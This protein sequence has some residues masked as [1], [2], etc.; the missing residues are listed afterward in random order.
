MK[1]ARL[2]PVI[3]SL[4]LLMVTCLVF[5]SSCKKNDDDD[6]NNNVKV[7]QVLSTLEVTQ[8]S[9]TTAMS[10]GVITFDGGSTI[11]ERGVCWS[12]GLTPTIA[13]NKTS[14]GT[15]AGTFISSI[16]GLTPGTQYYLRAYATNAKGT[17]YGSTMSFKTKSIVTDKDGNVYKTVTIGSQEWLAENLKT[18]KLNDGT[19]IQQVTSLYNWYECTTPAYCWYENNIQEYATTYGALYNWY[20]VNT[21]KLCPEGWHVPSRGDWSVLFNYLGGENVAGARLKESGF[22]HWDY[23]NL[24]A[25]NDVQFT[26]LPGGYRDVYWIDF[27]GLGWLCQFW[28]STTKG[29]S[30]YYTYGMRETEAYVFSREVEDNAGH[31]VRC[32]KD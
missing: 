13:D 28:S 11:T 19:P 2:L 4:F 17:G 15:G 27:T 22:D 32:V 31:S 25:T 20:T 8:V 12:T 5:T 23:P 3:S 29:D 21:N 18:T 6:D 14:N 9:T 24:G 26:A 10:G 1:K 7:D 16:G 30:V